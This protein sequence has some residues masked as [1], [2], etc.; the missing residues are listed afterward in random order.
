MNIEFAVR[1]NLVAQV[2]AMVAE[3][4]W[5]RDPPPAGHMR[6]IDFYNSNDLLVAIVVGAQHFKDSHGYIPPLS[7][8][9]SYSERLYARKYFAPLPM[10]SLADKLEGHAYVRGCLGDAFIPSVVWVGESID[11][12]FA[13]DLPPGRYFLKASHGCGYHLVLTLPKD[14]VASR[15]QIRRLADAWRVTRFGYDTG[16]WQYCTFKPRLFLERFI[17]YRGDEPPEEY[18]LYCFNGRAEFINFRVERAGEHAGALYDLAW[19]RLPVDFGRP[20]V[21]RD[22]PKNLEAMIEAAER[23]ATGL[24]FARIDLYSDGIE[25]VKFSE[26]TF[27]PGNARSRLSNPDFDARIGKLLDVGM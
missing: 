12:L 16:E 19:S 3:G 9:T 14:L 22:R 2:R 21:H 26:I 25:D 1:D 18:K 23:I 6:G 17:D 7:N 10:P 20:P 8:P 13:A 15:E 5:P 27:T 4:R 11:A 24:S